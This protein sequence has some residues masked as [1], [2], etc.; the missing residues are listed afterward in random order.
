MTRKI[1]RLL[2]FI[3]DMEDIPPVHREVL[4]ARIEPE[5]SK[6]ELDAACAKVPGYEWRA[7]QAESN[8]TA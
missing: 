2:D 5:P 6:E 3:D 4:K 7:E 1:D 8:A